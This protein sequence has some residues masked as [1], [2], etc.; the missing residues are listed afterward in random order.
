MVEKFTTSIYW[1]YQMVQFIT[2]SCPISFFS[3]YPLSHF[4]SKSNATAN[5]LQLQ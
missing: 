4:N 5:T 2:S 1:T 3:A